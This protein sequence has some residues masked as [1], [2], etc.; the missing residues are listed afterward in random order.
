MQ[1]EWIGTPR[2]FLEKWIAD[3]DLP[4]STI[5]TLCCTGTGIRRTQEPVLSTPTPLRDEAITSIL[6]AWMRGSARHLEW[7]L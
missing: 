7:R 6:S 2:M 5:A 4:V 3:I 1:L